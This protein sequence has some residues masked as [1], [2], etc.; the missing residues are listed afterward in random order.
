MKPQAI[1]FDLDGTL[2]DTAHDIVHTVNELR[3]RYGKSALPLAALRAFV[4][5]GAKKLLKLAFDVEEHDEMYPSLFSQLLELSEK[6]I[7][8]STTFFEGMETILMMLEKN[9][10][11][12]GIVT[13]RPERLTFPLIKNLN[14]DQRAACV[15]GGDTL[16]KA[17][18]FPDPILRACELINKKPSECIYVG[19]AETDVLAS[20]A[21]GVF[22]I[23]ALYGYIAPHEEPAKW[24]AGAYIQHPSEMITWIK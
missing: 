13:N 3:E 19:D 20:Q 21:A 16:S 6:N 24:N 2:L 17:K 4:G 10:I 12:W 14:L 8:R 23:V 9:N 15:I 18:P 7:C 1:L 5:Q 22:S 11:P